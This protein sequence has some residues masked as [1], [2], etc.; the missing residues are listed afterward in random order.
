MKDGV[1]VHE[2]TH[3]KVHGRVEKIVSKWGALEAM[4]V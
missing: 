2:A 4:V 3:V 1:S